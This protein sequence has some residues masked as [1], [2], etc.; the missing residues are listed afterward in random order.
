MSSNLTAGIKMCRE[1]TVNNKHCQTQQDLHVAM[2]YGKLVFDD[3]NYEYHSK[4]CLCPVDIEKTAYANGYKFYQ[5]D[6]G[7]FVFYE[8]R[9]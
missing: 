6:I 1:I 2:K 5:N 7:D 4:H 3:E 9:A 8:E